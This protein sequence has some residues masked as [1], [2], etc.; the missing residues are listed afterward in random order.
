MRSKPRPVLSSRTSRV[1]A[2]VFAA[3]IG[4]ASCSTS[5]SEPSGE[6]TAPDTSGAAESEDTTGAEAVDELEA[7]TVRPAA[8]VFPDPPEVPDAANA[9]AEDAI[10]RIVAGIGFGSLDP[11]AVDDLTES[12]DA[13]HAWFV[14]DMLRFFQGEDSGR[15]VESFETMTGVSIA[16]DPESQ[17]SPWSSVTNHLIAWDTPAYDGYR[18]DKGVIFKQLEPDWAPFFDDADAAIDWRY[19]SWGGVFIDDRPLGDEDGCPGGCIP[20]LDDPET[21]DAVSGNWYPDDRTVFGIVVDGEALAIPLNIAEI[22]EMFNLTL[23]DRR[24]AIPYCTLCGSAQAYFTDQPDGSPT[25]GADE[26]PVGRTSGLL[27]RS[28]KVMYD[29]LSDSVFDT[30]TGAAVSGPLQD[31]GVVLDETTVVRS[32]WSEWKREHPDTQIIAEDGGIGRT[33]QLDPL[34]SRDD[35]G[36]IFPIGDFDQRLGVQ[37]F[38]VGV[39]LEDG[40][41]LAFPSEEASAAFNAGDPVEL[42]GVE[43]RQSGDGLVAVDAESGDEITAHEAFWFAWSQFHPGTLLW[44]R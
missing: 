17:R 7:T 10:D 30:F 15:L 6:S 13:R 14:S 21:T 18:E 2:L 19:L 12:G 38:V 24:L 28:N 22:H 34:G 9:D 33:Y 29:L 37:E 5:D 40:T 26:V 39:L 32:T 11:T 3:A 36:P 35:D 16:D 23:G 8:Y 1:T 20:A 27:S 42:G 4:V 43:L 41:A 44:E 31:S 25:E